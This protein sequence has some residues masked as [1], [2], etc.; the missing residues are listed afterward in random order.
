[1]PDQR[2]PSLPVPPTPLVGRGR[3]GAAVRERLLDPAVRLLTLT[4]PGGT[5][6]T[7]LAIEVASGLAG[8]FP[9]G[10]AFVPLAAIRDP[11]LVPSAIAQALGVLDAGGRPILDGL[12]DV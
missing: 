2:P 4:G 7:R 10:L 1:M 6:K 11:S 12:Q 5:G 8:A 9:D 3:E